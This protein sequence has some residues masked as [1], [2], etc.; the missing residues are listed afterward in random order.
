MTP[1]DR[2]VFAEYPGFTRGGMPDGEDEQAISRTMACDIHR[3]HVRPQMLAFS[4][5]IIAWHGEKY[6]TMMENDNAGR[7]A[8]LKPM[9]CEK[10]K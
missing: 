4:Y 8:G 7:M 5:A 3:V 10:P 1:V 9:G 2:H 6:G